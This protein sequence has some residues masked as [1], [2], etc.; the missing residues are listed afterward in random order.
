[1]KVFLRIA[2]FLIIVVGVFAGYVWFGV[3]QKKIDLQKESK[4]FYIPTGSSF[5]EVVQT[6]KDSS[7]IDNQNWFQQVA[8]IRHLPGNIYPG[9]Y[10][11]KNGI[12]W[13]DLIL[14]LRSGQVEEVTVT[15]NNVRTIP[16]LC[17]KI[18]QNIEASTTDL[19]YLLNDTE[20]QRALGFNEQTFLSLFL[21]NS[22]RFYWNTSAE[23]FL[24]RM[25]KEYKAFWNEDRKAKAKALGMTQSEVSTLASIVQAEQSSI[26][27]EWPTIAGLYI[28]RLQQG[29]KLESDPTVIFGVGDFS[30]RRVLHK[31]LESNSP[32]N[33]YRRRGLPPGPIRIPST[34][35]IDAV[36]NYKRHDFIFMCAAPEMTGRHRF[37]ASYRKHLQN[38]REFQQALNKRKIYN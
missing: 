15:F 20:K 18:S 28:N 25:Q 4:A 17:E 29:I 26:E 6:L 30:I 36:L 5:E 37:T 32:Y 2:V 38:A 27:D 33:T 31:H 21:P 7:I 16:E 24:K 35:A 14:Q 3:F 34:R 9:K 11:I 8:E 10:T 19:L 22:Y 12:T 1:M 13:T 23:D